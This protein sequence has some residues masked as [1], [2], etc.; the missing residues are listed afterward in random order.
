MRAI[1]E[2]FYAN[3][4]RGIEGKNTGFDDF[5]C[6]MTEKKEMK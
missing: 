2:N 5:V 3:F 1:T 4:M 6:A